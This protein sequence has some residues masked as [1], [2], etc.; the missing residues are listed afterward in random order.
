MHVGILPL[1]MSVCHNHVYYLKSP[2]EDL[3]TIWVLKIEPGSLE[4]QSGF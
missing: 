2:G 1:G 3:A 4:E